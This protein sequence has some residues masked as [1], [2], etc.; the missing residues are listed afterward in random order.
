MSNAD[1]VP[2]FSNSLMLLKLPAWPQAWGMEYGK[3]VVGFARQQLEHGV[4]AM[5]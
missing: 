4:A 2:A 3:A 5:S 1:G